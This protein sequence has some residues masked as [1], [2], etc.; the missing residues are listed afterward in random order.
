MRISLSCYDRCQSTSLD[1]LKRHTC[2]VPPIRRQS[3]ILTLVLI[4]WRGKINQRSLTRGFLAS[5]LFSLFTASRSERGHYNRPYMKYL[6]VSLPTKWRMEFVLCNELIKHWTETR[7]YA[8]LLSGSCRSAARGRTVFANSVAVNCCRFVI[9]VKWSA[10]TAERAKPIH[11]SLL[12]CWDCCETS[13][14]C[15]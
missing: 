3:Q 12:T 2:K 4:Y 7:M 15:L 10:V 6:A 13:L 11:I 9:I 8:L 1:R 14:G 5:C